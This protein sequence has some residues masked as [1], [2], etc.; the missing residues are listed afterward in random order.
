MYFA[1]SIDP[2]KIPAD[3][4]YAALYADGDFA[5][6]DR[7]LIRRFTHRRWITVTGDN[8][9]CGIGDYEQGNSLFSNQFMLHHWAEERWRTAHVPPIIYTDMTNLHEATTA[10]QGLPRLWWIATRNHGDLTKSELLA[11]IA[12]EVGYIMPGDDL[13]AHQFEDV[14]GEYDRSRLYG[15][16]YK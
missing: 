13:W 5:V 15:R 12:T 7:E 1:D 2:A 9:R 8:P 11:L 10:L 4:E 16:W 6:Q 3:Y 14:N